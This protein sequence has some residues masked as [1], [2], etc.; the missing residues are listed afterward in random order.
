VEFKYPL[1]IT[2]TP[3]EKPEE[4]NFL[5]HI[6]LQAHANGP[7]RKTDDDKRCSIRNMSHFILP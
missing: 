4:F 2:I 5:L 3:C 7:K 6:Y 1:Y